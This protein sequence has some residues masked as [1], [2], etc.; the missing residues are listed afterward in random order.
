MSHNFNVRYNFLL[1]LLLVICQTVDLS[2]RLFLLLF[3]IVGFF[4]FFSIIFIFFIIKFPVFFL[5]KIYNFNHH[6]DFAFSE[7]F[8]EKLLDCYLG[9]VAIEKV[10]Q[11]L[12]GVLDEPEIR[13]RL[14]LKSFV[15]NEL[16][17]KWGV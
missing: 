17:Y 9:L 7:A 14:Q 3:S 1:L 15:G 11:K 2:D 4:I 5:H 6:N 8:G 12:I 10:K 16:C 13:F